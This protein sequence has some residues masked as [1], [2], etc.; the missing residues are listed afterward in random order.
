MIQENLIGN[1]IGSLIIVKDLG[2]RI[3][4]EHLFKN[5][6]KIYSQTRRYYLVKCKCGSE[7]KMRADNLNSGR[8]MQCS[9]CSNKKNLNPI[10]HN[11]SH[12][13]EYNT[14]RG[15]KQRCTNK[16]DKSFKDY[17][18]RGIAVCER[19]LHSFENFITDM[20]L[21]PSLKHS[22]DRI[23]NDGGYEPSNC[24]WATRKEQNKNKRYPNKN[25]HT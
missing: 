10:T 15:M 12:S 23:N 18:G 2:M 6:G 13:K 24:R 5:R 1:K 7:L 22:I 17:G 19:W 11:M 14:W 9:F 4:G 20:G 8:S 21:K 16:K 25:L 3:T